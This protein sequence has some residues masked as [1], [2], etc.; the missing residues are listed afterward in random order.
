MNWLFYIA[1]AL[2]TFI[3]MEGF[4]WCLH[5]YV[6]HGFAGV[7]QRYERVAPF[8]GPRGLVSGRVGNAESHVIAAPEL[9]TVA[10]AALRLDPFAFVLQEHELPLALG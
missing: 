1:I 5:R 2:I 3:L 10:L 4:T 6:M 8:L 7:E 9:L